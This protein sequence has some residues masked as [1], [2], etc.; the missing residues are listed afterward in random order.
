M[1]TSWLFTKR[2][3][4]FELGTTEKQN[5]ASD[6]VEALNP[7]PPDYNTSALNHLATLPPWNEALEKWKLYTCRWP[8]VTLA[9]P[10]RQPSVGNIS[11]VVW[12]FGNSPR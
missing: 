1:Q 4:G 6:M 3:W 8:L 5:P 7:E 2:D 10:C 12:S 11:L 9:C